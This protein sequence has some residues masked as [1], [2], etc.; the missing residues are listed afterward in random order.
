[1]CERAFN[2][3]QTLPHQDNDRL[4][5][6][7]SF[8]NKL[9]EKIKRIENEDTKNGLLGALALLFEEPTITVNN[10]NDNM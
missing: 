10:S 9:E 2:L 3:A 8:Q 6:A 5:N 7:L 4:I 1:M